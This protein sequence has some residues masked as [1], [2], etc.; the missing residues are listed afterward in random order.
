MGHNHA[1]HST[2]RRRLQLVL[3]ISVAAAVGQGV[4]AH[5]SSSLALA[6]DAAHLVGDSFGIVVALV[7]M[8]VAR[9]PRGPGSPSSFGLLRTEILAAGVNGILVLGLSL[10]IAVT[11]VRRL[12]TP[13]P[14]DV[15]WVF[16]AAA[17]ALVA[18]VIGMLLLKQGAEHSLNMRGAYLEVLGDT[19]GSL[20]VLV[21]ALIVWATGW[22]YADTLASLF[23][24]LLMA[25]RAV[26]LLIE[27]GS[28]LMERTPAGVHL[29]MLRDHLLSVDGV[30]DVHDVHVWQ[31]TSDLPVLT[32]HISVG[33]SVVAMTAAHEILDQLHACVRDHFDVEHSTFQIE[34]LGHRAVESQAHA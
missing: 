15:G 32:A 8:S 13:H 1:E 22:L 19:L 23:I 3:G 5:F 28:V 30:V 26:R 14:I 18:N 20:A 7:A 25:P 9:R 2:N 12:M 29:E 21:S 33:E 11:A 27:V 34:P 17:I 24:A 31:I 4:V 16:V 6:A 10:T